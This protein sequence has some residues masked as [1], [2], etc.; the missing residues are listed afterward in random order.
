MNSNKVIFLL[1]T[2]IDKGKIKKMEYLVPI[3]STFCPFYGNS[4][5]QVHPDVLRGKQLVNLTIRFMWWV[6]YFL[7]YHGIVKTFDIYHLW[8]HYVYVQAEV[9]VS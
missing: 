7:Y 8:N 3:I 6:E 9:S 4:E 1:I 5:V 2:Q